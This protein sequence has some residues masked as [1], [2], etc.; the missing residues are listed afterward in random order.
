MKRLVE[1]TWRDANF[2]LDEVVGPLEM[3]TVGWLVEEHESHVV[4]AGE[5]AGGDDYFRSFTAIPRE[6]ICNVRD[7]GGK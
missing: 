5:Y 3:Q 1:V 4:V 6:C 7:L 2:N